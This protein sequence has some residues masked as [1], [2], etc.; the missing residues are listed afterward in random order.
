[1]DATNLSLFDKNM[2]TID[3]LADHLDS[4]PTLT[5]WFRAQWPDYFAD[6]SQAEME[7]D[8]LS[9]HRVTVFPSVL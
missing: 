3:F 4:I 7:Q 2:I 9:E 5:K 8:F 1:V 6:W